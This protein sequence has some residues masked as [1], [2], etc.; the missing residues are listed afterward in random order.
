VFLLKIISTDERQI[1]NEKIALMYNKREEIE[2]IAVCMIDT[3]TPIP[4][5]D[6]VK[7]LLSCSNLELNH[8][9]TP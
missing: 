3:K 8:A 2:S 7:R 1:I 9:D 6:R 5:T 4:A